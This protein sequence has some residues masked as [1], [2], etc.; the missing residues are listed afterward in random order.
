MSNVKSQAEL[1]HCALEELARS[2]D[3]S[4]ELWGDGYA[5]YSPGLQKY[6]YKAKDSRA[7]T[8]VLLALLET[9]L[10]MLD[11]GKDR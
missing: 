8:S 1:K 9:S 5:L 6:L 3:L 7:I 10:S 11:A 2:V 4:L